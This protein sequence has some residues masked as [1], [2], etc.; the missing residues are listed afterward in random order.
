MILDEKLRPWLL[1]VNI[2][3]SL[4]SASSLDHSVKGPLI[5]DLLN[6]VG[7]HIPDKL[8]PAR[9][10][11]LIEE[12]NLNEKVQNLCLDRRLYTR[13]NTLEEQVIF[14]FSVYNGKFTDQIIFSLNMS[15]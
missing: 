5:A 10:K 12:L 1:E 6:M 2:S 9:Q 11:E 7:F 3:P 13:L 14:L 15:E 8:T 4:H